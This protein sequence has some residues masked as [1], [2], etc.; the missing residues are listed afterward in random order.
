MKFYV[1]WKWIVPWVY[2]SWKEC[3]DNI[4]WYSNAKYKSFPTQRLAQKAYNEH[5]NKYIGNYSSKTKNLFTTNY[6]RNSIVVDWACKNNTNWDMEFQCL[7]METWEYIFQSKVYRGGT[8]NISEFLA[9][10]E[11]IKWKNENNFNWIIYSDS[12]IAISWIKRGVCNT[13]YKKLKNNDLRKYI[14]EALEYIQGKTFPIY[15]WDTR[16]WGE[17]PADYGRK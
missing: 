13:D 11:A 9:L 8:N 6:T 4:K 5:Y 14:L 10:Y 2:N 15:K 12:T 3:E 17:N 7:N 16:E 1:V